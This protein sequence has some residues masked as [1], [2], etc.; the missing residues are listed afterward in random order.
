MGNFRIE[1][2]ADRIAEG[3][4]IEVEY[5]RE[6]VLGTEEVD[7]DMRMA[8][9]GE[10]LHELTNSWEVTEP[11]AEGWLWLDSVSQVLLNDTSVSFTYQ[12]IESASVLVKSDE[13]L[14][15]G[16]SEKHEHS[17][18]DIMCVELYHELHH[19]GCITCSS[20]DT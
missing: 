17:C 16:D 7:H 3:P 9:G 14:Y 8:V 10:G 18:R 13:E 12:S 1:D 2:S 15:E 4:G 11:E 20:V 6:F 5:W 19:A